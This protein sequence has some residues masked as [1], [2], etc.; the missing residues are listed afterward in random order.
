[1]ERTPGAWSWDQEGPRLI[2]WEQVHRYL[3]FVPYHI[4]NWFSILIPSRCFKFVRE[5]S[6]EEDDIDM[7]HCG[8]GAFIRLVLNCVF[9]WQLA[10]T[11]SKDN[12]N[13]KKRRASKI[14]PRDLWSLRNSLYFWQEIE[15]NNINICWKP[16]I[17]NK[18][19]QHSQSLQYSFH[20]P[21]LLYFSITI[22]SRH[23]KIFLMI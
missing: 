10:Q 23:L 11:M 12:D 8:V 18:K 20:Q 1:M 5:S 22:I 21:K 13:E 15:N 14:N 9:A 2:L 4:Y 7:L 19:E 6:S 16:S 17:K 3:H